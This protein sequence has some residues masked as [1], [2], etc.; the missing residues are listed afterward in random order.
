MS[1]RHQFLFLG[2]L[3][4]S[5]PMQAQP[6]LADTSDA[7]LMQSQKDLQGGAVVL[8][9]ALAPGFEDL[10]TLAYYRLNKGAEIKCVYITNGEDIPNY[11][12]GSDALETAKIRKEEA[13]QAMNVLNGEAY[14]LNIPAAASLVQPLDAG[15]FESSWKRLDTIIADTKP[16]IILLHLDYPWLQAESRRL[17][18]L[19]RE[20]KQ[21]LKRLKTQGQWSDASVF[22]QTQETKRGSLI[23]T[24]RQDEWRKESYRQLGEEIQRNYKSMGAV[25]HNL[26]NAFPSSYFPIYPSNAHDIESLTDQL[27]FV[28]SGLKTFASSLKKNPLQSP[29]VSMEMKLVFLQNIISRLDSVIN[30]H[31]QTLQLREQ[32]LLRYW[33]DAAEGARCVLRNV[34]IPYALTDDR[35]TALQVFFVRI[36][37]FGAWYNTGKTSVLFP[38]VIQKEWILDYRQDYTYPLKPDT[39][40]LIV[41]PKIFP[42]TSPSVD[43]GYQAAQVRRK[44]TMMVIHEEDQSFKN[45]LYQRD[46]MLRSVPRQSIE[47]LTP[48]VAANRDSTII[49]RITNNL[50]NAMDG[51]IQAD[52]SLVT[53]PAHQ[54]RLKPKSSE[55]DTLAFTW[56]RYQTSDHEVILKSK[57]GRSIGKF[58]S[59]G[60]TLKTNDDRAVGVIT[61]IASSPLLSALHRIGYPAA[62]LDLSDRQCFE[63]VNTIIM[64]EQSAP[65]VDIHS[66]AGQRLKTWLTSGGHLIVLPQYGSR[67]LV[68]DDS[69]VFRYGHAIISSDS[70]SLDTVG[71]IFHS[72]NHV[73]FTRWSNKESAIAYGDIRLEQH[74]TAIIPLQSRRTKIPLM[75]IRPYGRGVIQYL[76][77]NL[78]PQLLTVQAEAYKF[79]VNILQ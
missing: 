55:I 25:F 38:G 5:F 31:R 60:I 59:K 37:S 75:V 34:S 35:V 49:V 39:T 69:V 19:Q 63:H 43:D 53:L 73:D 74:T 41:S 48:V 13:F 36:G 45:F 44:F 14:F 42:L 32:R 66:E 71:R 20:L 16:D 79:L 47:I 76:A 78:H 30:R 65:L 11:E 7:A 64:D 1:K 54:I 51:V 72:P 50:F 8:S 58:I 33:K 21:I 4:W 2:L 67:A 29:K 6:L 46:I 56:K 23:P 61:S 3:S 17:A 77:L 28:P 15:K 68:P 12:N 9:I 27:P 24:D 26:K 40:W 62:V 70:I 22:L 57:K 10:S 18:A 52:D